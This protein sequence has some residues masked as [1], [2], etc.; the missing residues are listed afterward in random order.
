M[1]NLCS[2]LF[3]SSHDALCTFDKNGELISINTAFC[4]MLGYTKAELLQKTIDDIA[5]PDDVQRCH[6]LLQLL[7]TTKEFKTEARFLSASHGWIT[8]L[9]SAAFDDE[10]GNIYS[11]LTKTAHHNEPLLPYKFNYIINSFT[12]GFLMLN[13]NW[14]VTASNPNFLSIMELPAQN[15]IGKDIRQVIDPEKDPAVGSAIQ[16]AFDG[17]LTSYYQCKS[18]T[19]KK[20]IRFNTYYYDNDI[21]LFIRDISDVKKQEFTLAIEKEVLEMNASNRATLY[22]II[23]R[24]LTGIE[25]IFPDMICSVAEIDEAKQQMYHLAAPRLPQPYCDAINGIKI[26]PETASCGTAAYLKK[27][28]IVSDIATDAL[29]ADYKHIALQHNLRACWSTPVADSQ[30]KN[31]LATL[32]IYYNTVRAPTDNEMEM[33]NRTANIIRVLIESERNQ[34][35]LLDQNKRLRDIAEISSHNIRKPLASILGLVQLFDK[36]NLQNPLNNEVIDY[37]QASSEE[38]DLVIRTIIQKTFDVDD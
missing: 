1:N 25:E 18:K 8:L 32:G 14:Q 31:I 38:L 28:V 21:I 7:P 13:S 33:I 19:L 34:A 2:F 24:L 9:L 26:G 10:S 5:H 30:N 23:N 29:W 6:N 4:S 36:E 22:Q 37:L 11:R 17:S 20:W 3:N 15:I 12:E 35:H 16:Q 27:Q